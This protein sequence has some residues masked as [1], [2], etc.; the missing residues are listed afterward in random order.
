[1]TY[2]VDICYISCT[3]N[4]NTVLQCLTWQ[5]NHPWHYYYHLLFVRNSS[6]KTHGPPLSKWNKRP[7]P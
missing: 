5:Q 7:K 2:Y 6:T 1:M 3:P 4:V